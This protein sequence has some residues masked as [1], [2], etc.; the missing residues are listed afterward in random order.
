MIALLQRVNEAAVWVDG[1]RIAAIDAGI[2]A[3]IAVE[4]ED[5][6]ESARRLAE[7]LIHYRLFSDES[8]RMSRSLKDTRGALLAVPQFT[9][10]ADTAKGLR[11]SFSPA[12]PPDLG[13]ALFEVCVET[14]RC[15][16][17]DIQSGRFGADMKVH[18]V[19]DGP[20]TFLLK[21][22]PPVAEG[23]VAA[24]PSDFRT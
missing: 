14:L 20:V 9:L 22:P 5:N 13:R 15:L 7:R 4:K 2:L 23:Q 19:N 3:L 6:S 12:A 17:P 21:V 18:L 1:T 8:G 16:H 24:H 11:P 10:A